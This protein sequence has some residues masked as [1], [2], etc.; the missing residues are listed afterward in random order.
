MSFLSKIFGDPNEK[1]IKGLQPIIEKINSF[2]P[3]FEKFSAEQIK[4]KTK[5]FKERLQ[6]GETL[7]DILPE[8]FALVREASKR[9]LN[10]RHFDVQLIGGIVLYQGKI[11][12]MRTGE[13]KT[14]TATLAA[15]LNALEGHGVHIVTV[16]D[17][18]AKRDMVLMGQIYGALGLTT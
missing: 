18:L 13:G 5:E 4:E 10:Q 7:D 14:L 17:Y 12:E 1:F 6:K 2:A 11:A 3:E 16:N 8:A 15:Y 9:T